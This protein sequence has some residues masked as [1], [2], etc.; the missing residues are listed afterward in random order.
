MLPSTILN[1][2]YQRVNIVLTKDGIRTLADVVIGDSMCANL[3]PRSCTTQRFVAFNITHAKERNYY[4]Q[5]P[6]D[7]FLSLT[8]EVFGCLHKQ[9]D[10][11]LYK[12]ANA[13]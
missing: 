12:F 11:F 2:S 13:I 5:H 3:L 1:S 4:D 9:V 7:R 10:V 8:I 6:N